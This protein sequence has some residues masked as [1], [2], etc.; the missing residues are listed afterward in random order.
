MDVM[1]IHSAVL[2]QQVTEARAVQHGAGP[3]DASARPGGSLVGDT[4]QNIHPI[5]DDQNHRRRLLEHDFINDIVDDFDI[6]FEATP[7][8]IRRAAIWTPP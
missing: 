8:A 5:A 4:R 1:H 6:A 3:D 2:A 7:G